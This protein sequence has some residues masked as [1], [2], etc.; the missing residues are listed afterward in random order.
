MLGQ[1]L[2]S[3]PLV[4]SRVD[5]DPDVPRVR[6]ADQFVQRLC[7]APVVRHGVEVG[8]GVAV[9][10]ALHVLRVRRDPDGIEAQVC[11]GNSES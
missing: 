1:C 6:L 5:H 8:G 10:V 3:T 2:S 9:V 4:H 7:A 11:A